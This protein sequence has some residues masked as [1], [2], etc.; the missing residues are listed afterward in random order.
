MK[1]IISGY[2][3]VPEFFNA[4]LVLIREKLT[5]F[6]G[7][8]AAFNPFFPS[9]TPSS[10]FPSLNGDGVYIDPVNSGQG[11]IRSANNE[12]SANI[13]MADTDFDKKSS[14]KQNNC[15][16]VPLRNRFI[17]DST[18]RF[19]HPALCVCYDGVVHKAIERL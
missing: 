13:K 6:N 18:K 11:D 8:P 19:P 17:Y 9:S 1:H 2:D 12:D 16:F 10:S 5:L 3:G 14:P 4:L 7:P 15:T